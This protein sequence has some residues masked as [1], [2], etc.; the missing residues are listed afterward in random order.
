MKRHSHS[1]FTLV[2]LSIVILIIGLIVSGVSAGTSLIRSA[3]ITKTA[4]E[5]SFIRQ[6]YDTFYTTYKALPGDMSNASDLFSG[7]SNGNGNM[8]Y[9]GSAQSTIQDSEAQQAAQHLA[10]AGLIPG[11]YAAGSGTPV[12]PPAA[13]PTVL[14]SIYAPNAVYWPITPGLWNQYAIHNMIAFGGTTNSGWDSYAISAPDAY[15]IDLKIDDGLPGTGNIIAIN[16]TTANSCTNF[17]LASLGGSALNMG[18]QSYIFANTGV[19]TML[20]SFNGFSFYPGQ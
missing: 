17:S 5:I 9:D 18:T 10:L 15:N 14:P 8:I 19:C 4:Q 16:E 11:S 3:R 2:E 7:A 13:S 6:A 12:V 1:G 20:L